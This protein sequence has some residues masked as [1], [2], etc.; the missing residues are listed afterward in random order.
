VKA[1]TTTTKAPVAFLEE[2]VAFKNLNRNQ[3]EE[4]ESASQ[5]PTTSMFDRPSNFDPFSGMKR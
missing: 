2:L 1:T 4:A 3:G 5:N